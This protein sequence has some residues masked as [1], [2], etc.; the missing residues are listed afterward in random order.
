MPKQA[1][2]ILY[3]IDEL[4][5]EAKKAAMLPLQES[6]Y[7][8]D[9]EW[10]EQPII[11][12]G[13]LLGMAGFSAIKVDFSIQGY[14][15]GMFTGRF[16]NADIDFIPLAREY[17]AVLDKLKGIVSPI[18]AD[19]GTVTATITQSKF[20]AISSDAVSVV[21]VSFS[22]AEYDH[23]A[24]QHELDNFC[25]DDWD[26]VPHAMAAQ[27]LMQSRIEDAKAAEQQVVE[28]LTQVKNVLCEHIHE[29]LRTEYD[30]LCSDEGLLETMRCEGMLFLADGTRAPEFL[31]HS[32]IEVLEW[33]NIV[34]N[35]GMVMGYQCA[36]AENYVYTIEDHTHDGGEKPFVV[37]VTVV[38]DG[39]FITDM[40][41]D[42][43]TAAKNWAAKY[44]LGERS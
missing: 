2:V 18:S 27:E 29:V 31:E 40:V 32:A 22:E 5:A 25:M 10:W 7:N 39:E 4:G 42:T 13:E 38:N 14:K 15:S 35:D 11:K 9:H 28:Y 37:T 6:C 41:F 20:G 17:P 21:G 23:V 34:D 44:S 26:S 1:K 24:I 12:V 33:E 3:S 36:E 43:E 8:T 19:M 30:Y 16:S